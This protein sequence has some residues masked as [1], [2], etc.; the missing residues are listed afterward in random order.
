MELTKLCVKTGLGLTVLWLLSAPNCPAAGDAPVS[1]LRAYP[2]E[3][4]L[5]SAKARQQLVVQATAADG[6]TSDVTSL[7]TYSVA[8]PKLAR[9]DKRSLSPLADGRTELR[10]SFEGRT[11]AVPVVVSNAPVQ[12]P[13]SFKLDVMPVFTRAG[14]NSGACHGTSRGKDGFHLSLF[15]FDPEG[16]YYRLTR[17]QIGRRI[18]L[19]IPHESLI[20]QKGL[21][22]V[23]HTGGVRFGTNSDLCQTLIAWLAAGAPNDSSNVANVTGI[24]IFPKSAV[25]E[26][27]NTVQRLIVQAHYSDGTAR[28]VTPL[29]VFLGNNDVTARVAEDGTVTAGQRGEAF[30]Q[31]RFGA[32]NAGA[33]V[34]VI[35][36]GL[37]WHWPD[38]AANNYIDAAVYGK[39]K[40]LRL[41]PSGV[42]DDPTFLRRASLDIIG[43]LPTEKEIHQF[44]AEPQGERRGRLVDRLLERKE[45]AEQWVMKWAELLEIRT[46]DNQVYPKAVLNYFEWLRDQMLT[47][48]PLDQIVRS[49]LT[50]SGSNLREPA[51]NYYQIEPDTLKL[52]ENTAQ[53]FMGMRIQC[54]QCHNHPFDRWTMNDYYGFAAFFSQIGRK[55]GDDPR[56]T[57]IFDRHDGEVKHPVTGAVMRPK[58][59]GGETPELKGESRREALAR[60][61]TSPQNPYFAR[62][63]ANLLWAHFLGRGIIE[64]VDDARLSNP[65]SNPELLDALAAKLVEYKYDFKKVVRDICA[66]RT[67]QLDTRPN[68]TN[69]SDDRNFSKAAIRRLRAEVLLDCISQVTETQDKFSGLPRGAR[70]VEIADGNTANYFLTTFGRATRTTVCSCEV[71][72]DPN[73]SQALHLLNGYTV[74]RKIEEGGVV[75]KLLKEG[76]TPDQVIDDLYVRCLSRKPTSDEVGKLEEFLK[77]GAKQEQILDDVFWSLLNA[78]EFVFNH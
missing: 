16:D 32:F 50:A 5:G 61:I 34:I 15:G 18:D 44:E 49:L 62:S 60:W 77:D 30:V 24:E 58:F 73:L 9:L 23:Q 20:V 71:K 3:V 13:V 72:V 8:D 28:D 17:E 41:T 14:C 57:V 54:A 36:K 4:Q 7:A 53:V 25:M 38:V 2:P 48:V 6:I 21:G 12:P 66:S 70:A 46:R 40:K 10:V 51:A 11:V 31:A 47:N 65:A 29:A 45:F 35:P 68:D 76:E 43:T 67:Y 42:C 33:P 39:L 75:K 74:Q 19:G 52:A 26:G 78:K 55:P 63:V 27:S 1:D 37:S 56:E 22:A 64:P 69:A 59:L